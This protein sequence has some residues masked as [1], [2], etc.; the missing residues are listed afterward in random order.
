M[1]K[2]LT[3]EQLDSFSQDTWTKLSLEELNR[4]SKNVA[5]KK[6]RSKAMKKFDDAKL[7]E[8]IEDKIKSAKSV[9]VDTGQNSRGLEVEEFVLVVYLFNFLQNVLG[10]FVSQS[11]D[12]VS[13]DTI[14]KMIKNEQSKKCLAKAMGKVD[15][16]LTAETRET[17]LKDLRQLISP[18]K[19][20]EAE[21]VSTIRNKISELTELSES[22][23]NKADSA[24][25]AFAIE[26]LESLINSENSD[27]SEDS[28]DSE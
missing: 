20:R 25:I 26:V 17:M 6:S 11:L 18:K 3:L 5:S 16:E 24:K 23:K 9:H 7:A 21:I 12:N 14:T 27:K 22:S 10:L 2:P 28:K 4:L 8:K 13:L 19:V 1:N 15:R